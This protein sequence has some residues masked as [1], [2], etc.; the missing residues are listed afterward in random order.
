V[1]RFDA[2]WHRLAAATQS[3]DPALY[4]RCLATMTELAEQ[5]G[6]PT[7]QW[8]SLL[9]RSYHELVTGHAE[10][11]EQLAT[12]ALQ[13]GTATGQPDA[14]LTYGTPLLAIRWHQGRSG[15]L[16]DLIAGF[17]AD[18]RDIAGFRSWLA[19]IY[20]DAGRE[21]EARDLLAADIS[22]GFDVHTDY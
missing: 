10:R 6:Q 15:E 11:A 5:I 21:A 16:I 17:A 2:V 18:I 20:V 1:A 9:A 22:A 3:R 19:N 4:R 7:L 14:L 12:E 8:Y 13:V